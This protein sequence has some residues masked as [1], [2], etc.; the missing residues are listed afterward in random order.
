VSI[1]TG[2]RLAPPATNAPH[3]ILQVFELL[4]YIRSKLG[5]AHFKSFL[6]LA[7]FAIVAGVGGIATM[8]MFSGGQACN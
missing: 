2:W 3:H 8:S 1:C 7:I 5:E 4:R 6:N